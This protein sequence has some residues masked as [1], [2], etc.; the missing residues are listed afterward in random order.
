MFHYETEDGTEVILPRFDSVKPGVIRKIRK[1]SDVDQFFTVLEALAD[2][3]TLAVIDDL[4]QKEFQKLQTE[5][6]RHAG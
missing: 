4:E 1:L 2:E 3:D 6:F 5:W